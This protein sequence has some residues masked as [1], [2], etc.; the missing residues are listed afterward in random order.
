MRF[1]DIVGGVVF[2]PVI[3]ADRVL[4]NTPAIMFISKLYS[5]MFI[6]RYSRLNLQTA[7]TGYT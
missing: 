4:R 6:L 3:S 7:S 5:D 2:Y 1:S